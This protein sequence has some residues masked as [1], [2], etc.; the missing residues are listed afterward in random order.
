[1]AERSPHL[2]EVG[3][4][5]SLPGRFRSGSRYGSGHINETYLVEYETPGG[6]RRYIHQ[7][8]NRRAFPDPAAVMENVRRVLGHLRE[9]RAGMEPAQAVRR[10]LRLIDAADGR[11]C[12]WDEAGECW[13]TYDYVEGTRTVDILE[14]PDQAYQVARTFAEFQ[15]LLEDLPP[16]PL[17]ETIPR[18]HDTPL[19][20]RELREV[21]AAD[22]LDR[23]AAVAGEVEFA[24]AHEPM[25]GSLHRLRETGRL[26]PRVVH[27][28]TKINNVLLDAATG[29]GL[30]VVD[31]D[32]V[33]PGLS[34][35]DFGDLVRSAGN[36]VAEDH[37]DPS[38]VVVSPEVFY[39][40]AR[41]FRDGRG[42]ELSAGER[43]NLVRAGQVIA[44]ECGVRFLADYLDGDRYF[45]TRRPDQNRDRCRNQFALVRSLTEQE[46]MLREGVARL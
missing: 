33:M 21:L 31:L 11:P 39:A 45:R 37:P 41:G 7:R 36:P 20:F 8:L 27:N 35:V 29:E 12:A 10:T 18:F 25:A 22:P 42:G 23:G 32:T 1:M 40:L 34:L 44:L 16:P 26:A 38:R 9:K 13:R 14:S 15:H 17:R 28:D 5:F 24:L 2:E 19:R 30:C 3:R 46:P 4:Q 43:E 6:R